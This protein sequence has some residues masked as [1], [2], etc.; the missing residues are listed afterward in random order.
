MKNGLKCFS[1]AVKW[2]AYCRT[3]QKRTKM[4]ISIKD[5]AIVSSSLLECS[6]DVASEKFD[7]KNSCCY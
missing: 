6:D 3:R 1:L 5:E 7:C 4:M 2:G